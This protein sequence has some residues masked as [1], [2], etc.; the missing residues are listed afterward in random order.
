MRKAVVTYRREFIALVLLFGAGALIGGFILKNQRLRFPL[1]EE[2]PFQLKAEFSDAQAVVP[3]Q[4][5]TVRVAGMRVGDIGKV[6]L[7]NGKA[8]VTLDLDP[9]FDDLVHTDAG[10][11][12][13]PRTGLKDMFVELDPGSKKAPLMKKGG[14]ITVEN[15]APD[16]DAD[17]ILS[18][19]DSDTRAYLKLLI[20]GVGKGLKGRSN[21]LREV[22]RRLQPLHRDLARLNGAIAER[23]EN[24]A[25][26]VHNYGETITTLAKRDKELTSLVRDSRTAFGAIAS[27]DEG[28]S[29]AVR[30]LPSTLARVEGALRNIDVVGQE[31][32]PTFDALRPVVREL[33]RANAAVE[34]FAREA[35]PIV[36]ERIRP[37]VRSARPI[38][39]DLLPAARNLEKA[40][41]DL[42]E[43]F[44]ELN[45]FFN[46]AA[47]NPGGREGLSGDASKDRVRDEGYL[48][49][50]AWT[51]HNSNSIFSTSDA[52]GPFRRAIVLATCDTYQA[53]ATAEPAT[54]LITGIGNLLSDT[55]L[56]PPS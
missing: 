24:L 33:E 55:R 39:R 44:Y 51:A 50:L 8:V 48:F 38:V 35:E 30:R 19:L 16:I 32:K 52:Q 12:L 54:E 31:A 34:P 36:R 17:E 21:D 18:A 15:T 26:L 41:P 42:R 14:V 11:L 45:R 3:G 4:G 20:T 13:R 29:E 2:A 9:E 28:V 37:F 1:V 56:C 5:Q 23:R 27:E 40:S 47:Y 43:S 25:R 46:M 7:D 10:A 22:F 49:W 6:E 53:L